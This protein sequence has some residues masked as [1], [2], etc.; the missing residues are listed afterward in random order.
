MSST[1]LRLKNANF[2]IYAHLVSVGTPLKTS[3]LILQQ[4][5]LRQL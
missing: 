5:A 3:D 2:N 1:F 4:L